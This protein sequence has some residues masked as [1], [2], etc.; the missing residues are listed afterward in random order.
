MVGGLLP[1]IA[2][3]V[4]EQWYGPM[5]GAIAGIVFGGGEICW[6]IWRTG[7]VQKITWISNLLVIAFGA[8][9]L[10][11]SNGVFF[12]LQPAALLL[13]FTVLLFVTSFTKK[14]FL[15]LLAQKQNPNLPP[16]ALAL[17]TG[18]NLRLGFLFLLLTA[19][20]VHAAFYW[21]TVAWATLKGVGLPVL[22][23]I[24][25]LIEFGWLK[26]SRRKK[27]A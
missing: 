24:Y 4:V 26:Y 11:K 23:G 12:K 8:L 22:L 1:V 16:E 10:W 25:M 27:N 13:L 6:E 19:V 7:R 17:L 3:T 14:P 2:F 15:A 18:M 20:S 21:S 5:G 9:S